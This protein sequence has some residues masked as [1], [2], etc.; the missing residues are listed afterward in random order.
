MLYILFILYAISRFFSDTLRTV[1]LV[2]S[3]VSQWEHKFDQCAILSEE[4]A[5]SAVTADN[6]LA[7]HL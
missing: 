3:P 2:S 5:G 1:I 6:I 7:I 4:K